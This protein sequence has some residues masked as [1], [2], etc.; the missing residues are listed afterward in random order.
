VYLQGGSV[1]ELSI[2][3][4]KTRVIITGG[5][6]LLATN[7][8]RYIK[9]ECDVQLFLHNN[10]VN[11]P[12][13]TTKLVNLSN[14]KSVVEAVASFNAD[15]V[16]HTAGMTNV[17]MC[18]REPEQAYQVNVTL[19]ENIAKACAETD[20]KLVHISTDH[21]FNGTKSLVTEDEPVSPLN[22]Y[23]N[24]KAQAEEVVLRLLDD[25]IVIRTNFYGWGNQYKQSISDWIISLLNRKE[26]V[27]A[28]NDSYFTPIHVHQLIDGIHHLIEKQHTGTFNICG[29]ERVTKYEFAKRICAIFGFD[30]NLLKKTKIADAELFARR[31]IDM[32]LSDEK[33]SNLLGTSPGKLSKGLQSL[34]LSKNESNKI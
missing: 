18:E 34:Y 27:P 19:S 30:E 15:V 26:I 22:I 2:Y 31:P 29:N 14:T 4:Q 21:L 28:F 13:V 9:D 23:G 6:G 24:T 16:V 11:I 7:W 17:D 8:A 12:G 1:P 25:V 3:M 5:S 20:T 32:S 10:I 33:I